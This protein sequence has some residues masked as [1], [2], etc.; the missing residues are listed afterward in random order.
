MAAI[1]QL[2]GM[3]GQSEEGVPQ[4]EEKSGDDEIAIVSASTV[5]FTDLDFR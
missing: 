2:G 3:P 5:S 1:N 4:Q